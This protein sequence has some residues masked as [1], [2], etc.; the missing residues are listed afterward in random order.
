[1]LP[2]LRDEHNKLRAEANNL[3]EQNHVLS[4]ETTKLQRRVTRL[5]EMEETFNSIVRKEGHTLNTFRA[6]MQ[7]NKKILAEI[8]KHME[9]QIME[10]LLLAVIGSDRDKNFHIDEEEMDSLFMRLR[11]HEQINVNEKKLRSTFA[12]SGT[13]SMA[14]LVEVARALMDEDVLALE[15]QSE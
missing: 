2:S 3:M 15:A 8:N 1:M 5:K 10:D 12:A 11:Y 9:A 13:K 4:V 14:T 6:L 7:E